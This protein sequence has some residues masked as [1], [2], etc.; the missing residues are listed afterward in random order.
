MSSTP[1]PQPAAPAPSSAAL[2]DSARA[3][4]AA[5]RPNAW[6]LARLASAPHRLGFFAAAV[7]LAVTALWWLLALVAREASVAVPWAVPPAVAHGLAFALGFMPLFMIGFLFTAG[8][9][10]LGLP[11]ATTEHLV[12]PVITMLAGWPLALVGFHASAALAALGVAIVAAG[13][14]T[15]QYRFWGYIRASVAADQRHPRTVAVVMGI[16]AVAMVCA[17]LALALGEFDHA[18]AA[19]QLAIWGFLAPVFTTVS[20]RMIPFFSASAVPTLDAWRPYWL[21]NVMLLTL[22]VSG[23]GAVAEVL[24]WP[25]PAALRVALL[26][27]QAP[28]A[29]LMLWLA[30]RWGMV[31]SL[32]IRLLAMLHGGFVW[33]GLALAL[34]AC[35]QARV[36]WLG[37]QASLGLAPLHAL[38]MGYLGCTLIA[39][40]TRVTAGHSGRPLAA[41][42]TAW[43][44][45]LIV[46]AAV[47]LRVAAALWLAGAAVLTLLA[48]GAWAA[49][50]GGWALRYGSWLGRPRVDGRPG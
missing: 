44:L 19:I 46:Q 14:I 43:T 2:H 10:W 45:Y 38:T 29:V 26:L 3:G 41:D 7:M 11:D 16:G 47:L 31:Q 34:A 39:M 15:T 49:G 1:Q 48:I 33:F 25:L 42:N 6:H 40:I 23:L 20:H 12:R 32:R 21:L 30:W 18:R 4:A 22:G 5:E 28:A 13:W 27:V 50:C 9:R 24:W 17:A 36:L 8:P 37:P 35:S